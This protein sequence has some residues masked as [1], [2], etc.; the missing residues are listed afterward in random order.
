MPQ[1][2][3][4]KLT[5]ALNERQKSV[6]GAKILIIGIAYKK[7]IDDPRESPAFEIM[8]LLHGL[9]AEVSYHDPH[10]LEIGP[11]RRHPDK[12]GLRSTPLN[13]ETLSAQDAVLIVTDHAAV[14]YAEILTHARLVVDTRNALPAGGNVIKA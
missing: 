10:I 2:V 3:I 8:E 7:D 9:G 4:E 12:Q 1:Y 6:K 11:T 13:P 5:L 14:D